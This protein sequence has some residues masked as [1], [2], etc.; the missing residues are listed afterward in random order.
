MKTRHDA[1]EDG[2]SDD[3]RSPTPPTK[4]TLAKRRARRA[5]KPAPR[6][7]L[8]RPWAPAILAMFF[9][10]CGPDFDPPYVRGHH[11]ERRIGP[12]WAPTVPVPHS[13]APLTALP[14]RRLRA[15]P[16]PH[17]RLGDRWL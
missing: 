15:L 13:R 3:A 9:L 2:A 7:A 1:N 12:T 11:I 10:G 17:S 4:R 6:P 16:P 5:A 8:M 14:G